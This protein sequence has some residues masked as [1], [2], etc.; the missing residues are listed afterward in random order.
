MACDS[1]YSPKAVPCRSLP[2]MTSA[3]ETAGRGRRAAA[4]EVSRLADELVARTERYHRLTF[5]RR[6]EFLLTAS[7]E[8]HRRRSGGSARF[9]VLPVRG[10][11]FI[12]P[13]SMTEAR[14]RKIHLD[15][16]LQHELSH[17]LLHQRAGWFGW[18]AFPPWFEEGLATHSANQLGVDGYFDRQQVLDWWRAG[19]AVPPSEWASRLHDSKLI[20]ALPEGKRMYFVYSQFAVMIEDLQA[21]GG[22]DRFQSLIERL[23][24][25]EAMAKAFFAEY[26]KTPDEYFSDLVARSRPSN[27]GPDK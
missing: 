2:T 18:M 26:Q 12:A 23:L 16:Y 5:P 15:V 17:S 13:R 10:R 21:R 9:R 14:Q 19:R 24:R 27:A 6:A 25:G 4:L 3:S 11:L 20:D 7:E 8:E 22:R 1:S